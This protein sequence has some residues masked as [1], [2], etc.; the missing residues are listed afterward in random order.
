MN[1]VSDNILQNTILMQLMIYDKQKITTSRKSTDHHLLL[2]PKEQELEMRLLP[3][4]PTD[5]KHFSFNFKAT[6]MPKIARI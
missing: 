1:A 4:H 2:C 5:S 6:V 3:S